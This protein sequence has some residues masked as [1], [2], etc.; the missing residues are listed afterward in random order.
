[1]AGGEAPLT[2]ANAQFIADLGDRPRVDQGQISKVV[3]LVSRISAHDAIRNQKANAESDNKPI[4]VHFVQY[5][6]RLHPGHPDP[7]L[8]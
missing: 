2:L 1:M 3:V 6:G 7:P 5:L 8:I 4:W